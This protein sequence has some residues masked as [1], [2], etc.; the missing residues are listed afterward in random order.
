MRRHG[1]DFP[2]LLVHPTPGRTTV[3]AGVWLASGSA[4][5]PRALA[6]ATHMV[7][8]LTLRRCGGRDRFALARLVDRLGGDV[9]AWTSTELM[10]VTVQTTVDA[11]IEGLE[12]LVDAILDPS[13]DDEDVELERRV[14]LAELELLQDD[15][16]ERVEEDVL[17]AAWGDHPLARP[18]IGTSRSLAALTRHALRRHH[19]TMVQPGR[20]LAAVTGDV[21]RAELAER[22]QRLPLAAP[23]SP[24]N[25]PPLRWR[26]RHHEVRRPSADQA[27]V[28]LAFP[29]VAAASPEAAV[30]GVL[31]RI[32]GVGA[33]SRL[34]QRLREVEG[35]TYDIWSSTMLRRGGGLL[36]IGWACAPA[37]L[38]QVWTMVSEELR[39]VAIDLVDDEVE[40]AKEGLARGLAMDVEM[41]AA[42]CAMDVA[43][44]LDRG[45]R[46]DTEVARNEIAAVTP[47][48]VQR[49]AADMLR[50]ERMA[51]ALCGPDGVSVQVA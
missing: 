32:L 42:Y 13:F 46:F 19:A 11:L 41:P 39:R 21:D 7:E 26:G 48:Q 18:V 43:E 23:V 37:V 50:P 9:D 38:N 2:A 25:L 44:V 27:H 51:T 36:E 49:I 45:R 1:L 12:L 24:P 14:S 3:T 31:N 33:S 29:A 4:H 5:E 16:A 47:K 10:G 34:F 30:V 15:P 35:L 8:H 28:R 22:L 17:R 20:V 6:G 40:V